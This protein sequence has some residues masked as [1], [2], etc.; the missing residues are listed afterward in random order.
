MDLAGLSCNCCMMLSFLVRFAGVTE[1]VRTIQ[2]A[3]VD[4]DRWRLSFSMKED[5]EVIQCCM[6][7]PLWMRLG[8]ALMKSGRQGNWRIFVV[9][10]S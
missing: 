10:E 6:M 3:S 1:P 8:A 9:I 2:H 4:F 5:L 7:K